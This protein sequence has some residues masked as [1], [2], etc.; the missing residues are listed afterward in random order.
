MFSGKLVAAYLAL[1]G[2]PLLGLVGILRAGRRLTAPVSVGGTWDL[3]ADFSSLPDARCRELLAGINR[4]FMR[5]SQ[6]G[7][8]LTFI[9]NNPQET[10]LTGSV[11]QTTV[12]MG[13]TPPLVSS[14]GNCG[15]PRALYLEATVRGQGEQ[16]T[17]TGSLGMRGCASCPAVPFRAVRQTPPTKELQ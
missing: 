3:R 12:E 8:S 14:S 9:L 6:S 2:V 13:G 11:D 16:R 4:P 15:D 7:A 1:V 5:V 17:L 10:A